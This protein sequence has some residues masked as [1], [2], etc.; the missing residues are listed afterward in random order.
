MHTTP[1]NNGLNE[2]FAHYPDSVLIINLCDEVLYAN[3]SALRLLCRLPDY[4]GYLPPVLRVLNGEHQPISLH[5]IAGNEI[6]LEIKCQNIIWQDTHV[7]LL[8][9]CD[10]TR[11]MQRQR[12]LEQLVYRDELTGLYNRRGLDAQV[13]RLQAQSLHLQQKLNVLFIDVNGLKQ[14][15]DKLGA[16]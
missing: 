14:I 11:V 4:Q 8:T 2:L 15:N 9:L 13:Q 1:Q 16:L 5:D 6:I 12:E 7:K 3:S 10:R